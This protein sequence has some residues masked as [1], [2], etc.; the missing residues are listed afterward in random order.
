[1]KQDS[2]AADRTLYTYHSAFTTFSNPLFNDNDDFTSSDDESLPDE[3][4]LTGD[5]KV[6]LNLLFDDDEINS[7]EIDPHCFNIESDFVESLSNRD[8]LNDSSPKFD[9]LKEFS[10]ALMPTSVADEER[11]RREHAEYISLM[12]RLFTINPCPRLMEN[13]NAIIETP[14]SSPILLQ[15]N[16]SQREE[17]DIVTDTNELLP[18]GFENDDSE[19]EIDVVEE[20]LVDDSISLPENKSF[21]FDHQDDPS[22]PRPPLEPPDVEPN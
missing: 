3:D 1:M 10:G 21:Y 11:I 6:Y 18:P 5:F 20:L 7:D 8:T 15:D 16:D 2:R 9:F 4:V 12:E 14:P 19:V 17:I 22:F 13:S